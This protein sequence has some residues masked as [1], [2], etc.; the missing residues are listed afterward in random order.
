[1]QGETL[2]LHFRPKQCT[3]TS[4]TAP[5]QAETKLG[6]TR[7]GAFA[8][9]IWQGANL[10]L[11]SATEGLS[12]LAQAGLGGAARHHAPMLGAD[13][14]GSAGASAAPFCSSSIEILSGVR[15]NAMRPSRG[16]RLMTTP[17]A[18]N[19]AQSS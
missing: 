6:E 14:H 5:G 19:F 12:Q 7:L 1:M 13:F 10:A 17:S 16:G 3:S 15:M 2:F 18:C 4:F 8:G 11:A 9:M